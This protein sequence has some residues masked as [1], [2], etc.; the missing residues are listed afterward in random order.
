MTSSITRPAPVSE[1]LHR[2]MARAA[3]APSVHNSQPWRFRLSGDSLELRADRSRQLGVLDPTCRQLVISCGC[4]LFNARTL[5]SAIGYQPTVQRLPDPAEPDLLARLTVMTGAE[6]SPIAALNA[7]VEKR[8]TNRRQFSSDPVPAELVDELV[9]AAEA[10]EAGLF[11]IARPEHRIATAVLSQQADAQQNADPA[12]RAELRAWTSDDPT[13]RDGVPAS[14]VPHVDAG[15]GDDIPIR[16]FDSR[17]AG[18]LPTETR[19]SM[20]QCLLLLTTIRDSRPGWLRAGEAL[21]R[22]WLVATQRGYAMSLLTQVVEVPRTRQQLRDELGLDS[23]PLVLLRIGKAP[24]T[25]SS[26]R[27]PLA[28]LLLS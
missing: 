3:L 2:A 9:A 27:R 11:V 25:A 19:S 24:V 1:A 14:A 26:Q 21:E 7:L 15:A 16:D 8:Q 10:E 13:R 23:H 17:G 20:N 22:I 12:Y 4:A 18:W 6:A 5:L 28:D